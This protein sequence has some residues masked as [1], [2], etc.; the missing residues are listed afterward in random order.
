MRF[1]HTADWHLGRTIRG[2]SRAAEF[3]AVLAEV[4]E[5]ARA[6]RVEAMLVCGDIWDTASPSPESDRLLFETLRECIG[7]GIQVVLLAGNHDNPR[8]LEALGLLTELLG[9]QTQANVRRPNGGG[10]LT[11]EGREHVARIAAVPWVRE[12]KLINAAEVMGLQEEWF[13]SYQ[14]GVAAIFRSMCEGFTAET[15]NLMVAHV[16]IDGARLAA[17]DGSERLL[18]IGQGYGVSPASLPSQPQYIALGHIHQPQEVLTGVPTAYAGSLLQLDFGERGQQKV[19]RIVDAVPGRPVDLEVVEL[20][21]GRPLVELRGTLDEVL[22]QA[23][24]ARGGE[25]GDAHV[26]VRLDVERPEPGLV[27]R[28]REA[29]PAVVDVQLEYDAPDEGSTVAELAGRSPEEL[30]VQY[31]R[32]QHGTEPATDVL[33]LFRELLDEVAAPAA[34]D[35]GDHGGAAPVFATPSEAVPSETVPSE[36]VPSE[37]VPSETVPSET[38]A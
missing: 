24:Q 9:V 14:D 22:A 20:R 36:T 34:E 11:I 35:D 18:H 33:A 27:Q 26:R 3:E 6:E 30:F 17:V 7:H 31:Y 13:A 5:I 1:L 19:V 8:K 37:T 15:V 10:V 32:S 25:M 12:G 28:L 23:E 29:L 2:R 21:S 38:V 16:F 4:V